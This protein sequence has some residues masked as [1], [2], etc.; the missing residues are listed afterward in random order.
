MKLYTVMAVAGCMAISSLAF[1]GSDIKDS[2]ITNQATVVGSQNMAIGLGNEAN[3]G[4]VKI[5]DS[6]V[7]GSTITN[8][9]TVVGSQNMAIGLGNEANQASVVVK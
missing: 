3:Q 1:A 9:A 4:T 5:E 6:K 7:K 8:Q 2:R